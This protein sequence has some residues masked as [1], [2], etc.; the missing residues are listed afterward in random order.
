M[1]GWRRWRQASLI[2]ACPVD[3]LRGPTHIDGGR[4]SF[5]PNA[6]AH[7]NTAADHD[8]YQGRSC[9][10]P[11]PLLRCTS[12]LGKGYFAEQGLTLDLQTFRGASS[13]MP[14]LATGQLDV[15][16]VG[17]NAEPSMPS[18]R[19]WTSRWWPVSCPKNQ[20]MARCL[21]WSG[22]ICSSLVRPSASDLKGKERSRSMSHAA[23]LSMCC[24]RPW[25]EEVLRLDDVQL[26]QL[27]LPDLPS[28]LANKAIDA[29]V[30]GQPYGFLTVQGGSAVVLLKGDEIVDHFQ[31]GVL[32][33]GQRMLDPVNREG[34][35][36]FLAAFLK[37]G[38]DIQGD[39]WHK[40]EEPCHPERVYKVRD[41]LDR[42][43]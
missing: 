15:A 22:R 31:A 11:C 17:V 39:G 32:Y 8:H 37:G 30:P 25:R 12:R 27:P 18:P 19:A 41:A 2:F 6:G 34:G 38:R 3:G 1:S 40:Q 4:H 26:V 9:P 33:F 36:R 28:A 14:F 20:D 13:L 7:R 43:D 35:V 16:G 5:G 24:P 29:A 42:Q 23:F 10:P 21:F